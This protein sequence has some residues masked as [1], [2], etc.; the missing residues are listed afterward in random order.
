M[1]DEQNK[2]ENEQDI[3]P[4]VVQP[5][6]EVGVSPDGLSAVVKLGGEFREIHKLKAGKFYIAQKHFSEV[7]GVLADMLRNKDTA[8][9]VNQG[10]AD[11]NLEAS[12]SNTSK[13]LDPTLVEKLSTGNG[14]GIISNILGEVPAKL[15]RFVAVCCDMSEEELLDI[16]YPDEISDAFDVCYKLNN[17]MDSL[18]KF[19][20][21]MRNLA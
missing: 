6:R 13:P 20:A 14:I 21:P 7:Y 10:I 9:L 16:A 4:I 15:A 5:E 17:I 1:S 12:D 18:K 19:G 2:V 11:N 8:A 3:T